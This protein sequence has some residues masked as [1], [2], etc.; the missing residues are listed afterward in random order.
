MSVG[1][2]GVG[3]ITA[4]ITAG[5]GAAYLLQYLYHK[6]GSPGASWFMGNIAAVTVFCITYGVSLLVFDPQLRGAAE[7]VSFV[8][9]CFM[10]PF[11][12]AFGLDYTGR[13]DLIRSPLFGVVAAV[14]ISTILLAATNSAHGLVWTDFRLTPVFGLA[15]AQYTIETWGVFALLFSVGTA[16]VGSLLLIGAILSYGPLYRREATAV[17]LSTLPPSVGVLL[18]LF[19]LGP[20]PELHLTGPLMLIHVA[21]DGYAFVGT[22]MFETNP[23]TQRV[24][25]QTG[26]DKLTEP[27]MVLDTGENVVK[28]NERA[29]KLFERAQTADGL[30]PLSSLVGDGLSTLRETGEVEIGGPDGGIFAV[31]YTPLTDPSGDPVGGMIVLYDVREE[32]QRKQQLSVLNRVL[33]HN[34]RNEMTVIQGFAESLE[35]SLTDS[36]LQEQAATISRAG[37]RLLA[38]GEKVREID[39]MQDE[40]VHVEQIDVESMFAR[41]RQDLLEQFPDATIETDISVSDPTLCTRPSILELALANLAEN[42]LKHA[43]PAD[44]TVQLRM[45][46]VDRA[47]RPIAIEVRDTN[48]RISESETA[49]LRTGTESPLQH[50]QGIGLWIVNWCVTTLNGGIEYRYD[51][52]NTFIITLPPE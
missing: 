45:K 48:T 38:I 31:S 44:P 41:L 5:F 9:V 36:E 39:R 7:A 43:S 13:T 46:T 34:L 16:A 27:V 11:F 18:W 28:F 15:T 24:A 51:E 33:R 49:V 29:Q 30:V 17:T 14:P 50:G 37:D 8:S 32:R 52:G 3:V 42:A 12:L 35:R 20:V 21:L 2:I 4:S 19:D 1:P 40:V 26:L 22:H 6:R 25:E 23:A 47:D 10:G